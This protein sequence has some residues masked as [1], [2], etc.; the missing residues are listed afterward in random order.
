M[1]NNYTAENM[2]M[3]SG[4]PYFEINQFEV[5]FDYEFFDIN[6]C[7]LFFGSFAMFFSP[8]PYSDL[9]F[10]DAAQRLQVVPLEK[11]HYRDYLRK[12]F[13]KARAL[14]DCHASAVRVISYPFTYLWISIFLTF[15]FHRWIVK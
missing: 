11:R 5:S 9:I 13:L 7:A 15:I 3:I 8:A 14:V 12:E 4:T 2:K 10:Q 6:N 1:L